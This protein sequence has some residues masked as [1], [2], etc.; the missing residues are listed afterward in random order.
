MSHMKK[1]LSYRLVSVLILIL[2]L[3]TFGLVNC[4]TRNTETKEVENTPKYLTTAIMKIKV[5][6]YNSSSIMQGIVEGSSQCNANDMLREFTSYD[7]IGRTI[8]SLPIVQELA[9]RESLIE[10]FASRLQLNFMPEDSTLLN[11]QLIG[12]TPKIDRK[13]IDKLCEIYILQEVERKN[14]AANKSIEF[15]NQQLERWQ[16]SLRIS[17]EAMINLRQENK[18][19]DINSYAGELMIKASKYDQQQMALR[20]K[21]TYVDY[22]SAYLDQKNEQGVIIPPSTMG[23][24][25]PKL[26]QLVQQLNDLLIQPRK[27]TVKDVYYEKYTTEIENIKSVIL[28]IV[29]SMSASL[30]IENKELNER[31]S[32]IDKEISALPKKQR[33]IVTIE[34]NYRIDDNYNTFFLQKRA[35]AE[36]QKAGNTLDSE[37]KNRARS[38]KISY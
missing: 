24:N 9:S 28:E 32:K 14:L 15:I 3:F 20:L 29:Q 4:S 10:E 33:E 25:E 11:I 2:V 27:P 36:I 19:V 6:G 16:G 17:E 18:F 31:L 1:V 34:R 35:E 13:F 5:N 12:E 23:V 26:M 21:Q 8:D 30:V 37:I 7:L 22:L 38:T